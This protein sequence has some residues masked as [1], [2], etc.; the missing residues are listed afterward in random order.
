[1]PH[2]VV[3]AVAAA[4][5]ATIDAVDVAVVLFS[6]T[7]KRYYKA[8]RF[9]SFKSFD[10][11]CGSYVPISWISYSSLVVVFSALFPNNSR[12]VCRVKCD[13]SS[14]PTMCSC[15]CSSMLVLQEGGFVY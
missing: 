5:A 3:V 12:P 1:M 13:A 6:V 10:A 4:V 15:T 8:S 9:F 7:N 11:S 2:D 14:T